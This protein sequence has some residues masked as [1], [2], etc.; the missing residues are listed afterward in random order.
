M[1]L[2]LQ[3]HAYGRCAPSARKAMITSFVPCFKTAKIHTMRKLIPVSANIVIVGVP[4]GIA[5]C[6]VAVALFF[7]GQFVVSIFSLLLMVGLGLIISIYLSTLFVRNICIRR[8]SDRHAAIITK[9]GGQ[10]EAVIADSV[11]VWP[12][13]QRCDFRSMHLH[14][15]TFKHDCVTRDNVKLTYHF[16]VEW[17]EMLE[18]LPAIITE[19]RDGDEIVTRFVEAQATC[20]T[21][22]RPLDIIMSS[23]SAISSHV[24][25]R[26]A[27]LVDGPK[28]Y[29]FDVRSVTITKLDLPN[30]L[31][32][33][34]TSRKQMQIQREL[35]QSA[36][37]EQAHRLE[38]FNRVASQVHGR[39]LKHLQKMEAVKS[40]M[41]DNK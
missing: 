39:T 9:L 33:L 18:F 36:G 37:M 25:R 19:H 4:L 14:T 15:T 40:G 32:E 5:I 16:V 30:S 26:L 7:L 22:Q 27:M 8:I 41:L 31:N 13:L 38:E 35:A 3:R 6:L 29:G 10:I 17:E 2:V 1:S 28:Q 12:Y 24:F 23:S 21:N 34:Y 11:F 20:E